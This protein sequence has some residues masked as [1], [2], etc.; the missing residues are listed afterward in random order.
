[1][2]TTPT[3]AKIRDSES[4]VNYKDEVMK[5]AG[6]DAKAVRG[7]IAFVSP[8]DCLWN[9]NQDKIG[10]INLAKDPYHTA[11]KLVAD[12]EFKDAIAIY[13]YEPTTPQKYKLYYV[14]IRNRC[15]GV[16]VSANMHNHKLF[17][18]WL[19]PWMHSIAWVINGTMNYLSFEVDEEA[20][21]ERQKKM[22]TLRDPVP[23]LADLHTAR[24]IFKLSNAYRGPNIVVD[25]NNVPLMVEAVARYDI[26]DNATNTLPE[27]IEMIVLL[28]FSM[29]MVNKIYSESHNGRVFGTQSYKDCV[30]FMQEVKERQLMANLKQKLELEIPS[31]NTMDEEEKEVNKLRKTATT[32]STLF[33]TEDDKP[34]VIVERNGVIEKIND[35]HIDELGN[36]LEAV[37]ITEE[38]GGQPAPRIPRSRPI[39]Q[40][41]YFR[42]PD[43]DD[44]GDEFSDD[45]QSIPN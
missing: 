21:K 44:Y 4:N 27:L 16:D 43:I 32:A 10:K 22:H 31:S 14:S 30:A 5:E 18:G 37:H 36:A 9:R 7:R 28:S 33:A 40:K 35:Q 13:D 45:E 39:E 24:A 3:N 25:D 12:T 26:I 2:A 11:S 20:Y 29:E 34:L 42:N 19:R 17:S 23:L 15:S 8:K 1:M 6:E 38:G 41:I